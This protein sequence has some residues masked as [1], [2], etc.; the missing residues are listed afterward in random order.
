MRRFLLRHNQGQALPLVGLMAVVLFLMIGLAIDGGLLYAQRRVM[1]NT[2]D[3]AC[4]AAANSLALNKINTGLTLAQTAESAAQQV[5]LNNLGATPGS[6]VNAP[7]TLAYANISEIYS[8]QAGTGTDLTKGIEINGPDVRVAL[9]SPAN[10]FFM[11]AVGYNTYTVPARA[12]CDATAGGGGVPFAVARWRGYDTSGDIETDGLTTNKTLPQYYTQGS[13]NKVMTVRDI[14]AQEANSAICEPPGDAASC[15]NWPDWGAAD[16]PGDPTAGTGL[17]S[18]PTFPATEALPGPE[19]VIAGPDATPNVGDGS[20]SGP[21]VLDFRQTTFPSPLFYNGLQPTTALNQ[22]KDYATRYILGSY[23]GPFVIP[24]QQIAFYNGVSAG[25]IEKPFDQ[26][27][28]VGDKIAVLMYNGTINADP[29]FSVTFPAPSDS[30]ATR[31]AGSFTSGSAT[32]DVPSGEAFDGQTSSQTARKPDA[33]YKINVL[34]QT[35]STFKL[36]AFISSD[37]P[38]DWEGSWNSGSHQTFNINGAAPVVSVSTSGQN[39]TFGMRP[40]NTFDCTEPDPIDPLIMV[41]TTYPSRKNGAETIYL[42]VEDTATGKRRAIYVRLDQGAAS[43]DFYAYFSQVPVVYDPIEQGNSTQA[44][45]K[46]DTVSG[47]N[48]DIGL[49][50]SKVQV[51]T[52]EWY[53]ASNVNSSIGSGTSLNGVTV[54]V[55]KSGSKNQLT[56]DTSSTA[57]TGKEYYIRI[58]LTYGS[59]THYAWYYIAVRTPLSNASGIGKFVYALG[60]TNYKITEIGSNYIKGRAISGLM[61]DPT[62]IISG[63][64][65]RLLPWQ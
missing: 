34:P 39:Q 59:F 18:S 60:Y 9:Q 10:T 65:P 26:R 37:Q 43:N 31:S 49:G 12:H 40:T 47:S 13:T 1:Q 55:S 5:I 23:P 45:L 4:L 2:A 33:P 30:Q 54:D 22:Y 62:E 16:Y 53:D 29:D 44:E 36:R 38:D 3:A 6:G 64:Q 61:G 27:Y 56:I 8:A 17:Y 20:F 21:I 41:D 63:F 58:P 7:G 50:S 35:Y 28:N 32:C 46:L 15:D 42:E 25:L 52:I 57:T 11:R 24:G 48:L 14:I 19:T 51:G